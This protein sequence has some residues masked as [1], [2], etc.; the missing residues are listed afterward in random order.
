MI[1]LL[2]QDTIVFTTANGESIY[3]QANCIN[4]NGS[5]EPFSEI[6]TIAGDYTLIPADGSPAKPQRRLASMSFHNLASNPTETVLV[7]RE[8]SAA[9]V[10]IFL[11][12][13][14]S[15]AGGQTLWYESGHGWSI[16]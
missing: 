12:G 13:P 6:A 11:I 10:D 8:D 15:L 4:N 5:I 14:V 1:A 2:P 3:A 7:K 9:S 16:V